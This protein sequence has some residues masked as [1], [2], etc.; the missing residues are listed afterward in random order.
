MPFLYR[1][2]W[3]LPLLGILCVCAVGGV[4]SCQELEPEAF[5]P[6]W[7]V[8]QKWVV[9]TVGLQNQMRKAPQR[10]APNRPVRWQF[11]V[12]N[13]AEVEGKTCFRIVLRCLEPGENPETTLWV[14]QDSLTLL[15]IRMQL[16]S[17]EGFRTV[18]ETYR[19]ESGQPFPAI[20]VLTV[21]PIDLPLFIAGA[22]GT[23]SFQYRASTAPDGAKDA[24]NID[25]AIS[26]QQQLTEPNDDDLRRL[27]PEQF[28]K[29]AEH[30]PVVEVRL[31]TGR[32]DVRQLWKKGSPWPD[33]SNNGVAT[34]RLIRTDDAA[35]GAEG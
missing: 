4:A 17:R 23:S 19:S 6:S 27:L 11:K 2:Q 20:S 3:Q 31:K 22:K 18:T 15:K 8:G 21:P 14:D 26:I 13:V 7:K 34:S 30:A 28:A 9:E 32:S 12:E 29:S 25:F 10:A 5:R 33:Y 16:P 24:A 35:N 1:R